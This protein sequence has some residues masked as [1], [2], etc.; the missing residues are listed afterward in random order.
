MCGCEDGV[1]DERTEV[2]G[3]VT[4]PEASEVGRRVSSKGCFMGSF[5]VRGCIRDLEGCCGVR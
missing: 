1:V 2:E 4:L 5:R 3:E